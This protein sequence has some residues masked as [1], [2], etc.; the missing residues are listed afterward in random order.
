MLLGQA[1]YLAIAKTPW[2]ICNIANIIPQ[3]TP[4]RGILRRLPIL[5]IS[6][7]AN[8]QHISFTAEFMVRLPF[9]A[10][11]SHSLW[12]GLT[13][14][15]TVMMSAGVTAASHY[16]CLKLT[17]LFSRCIS[18]WVVAEM[19]GGSEKFTVQDHEMCAVLCVIHYEYE[20]RLMGSVW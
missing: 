16:S 17:I 3:C 10:S 12:V 15:P 6:A 13:N 4:N 19:V 14:V 11:D 5:T 18:S 7:S 8:M 1:V 20:A 2:W 9:S